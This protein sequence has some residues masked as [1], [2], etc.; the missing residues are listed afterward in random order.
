MEIKIIE[1]RPGKR[2]AAIE[3]PE[4]VR[5]FKIIRYPLS[6]KWLSSDTGAFNEWKVLLA[7]TTE[8]TTFKILGFS[9]ELNEEQCGDLMHVFDNKESFASFMLANGLVD[10]NPF[11]D[12]QPYVSIFDTHLDSACNV[13]R[14]EW[15]EAESKVKKYLIL[16]VE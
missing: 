5:K 13:R 11:G 3:V 15:Q 9:N 7:K 16:I 6:G 8:T 14:T 12:N 2:I 10:R 4:G 1:P